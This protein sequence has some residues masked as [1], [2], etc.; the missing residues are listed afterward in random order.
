MRHKFPAEWRTQNRARR[1]FYAKYMTW[2]ENLG[3][4]VVAAVV[5]GIAYSFFYRI[6]D[7]VSA[8]GVELRPVSSIVSSDSPVKVVRWLVDDLAEVERGVPVAEVLVG[9]NEIEAWER[10]EA[11]EEARRLAPDLVIGSAERPMAMTWVAESTG[12]IRVGSE[13]TVEPGGEIYRIEDYSAVVA[14]ATLGGETVN[15]ADVGQ[16]ARFGSISWGAANSPIFRVQSNQGPLVSRK[17]LGSAVAEALAGGLAGYAVRL[18]DDKALSIAGVESVEVEGDALFESGDGGGA[19][20][21]DP[22]REVKVVGTVTGGVASAVVQ[23]S[24]LPADV[25]EALEAEVRKEVEG[26]AVE[27][28]GGESGRLAAVDSLRYV[29]KLKTEGAAGNGARLLS[30]SRVDR[31][32][33]AQLRIDDPPAFLVR[34]MKEAARRGESVTAKVEVKTGTRPI[35]FILL[36]RS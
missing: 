12:T 26:T 29:V 21:L 23:T 2:L 32:F 3:F 25:Q 7:L 9:A 34:S 1:R 24:D 36:K 30:A 22:P 27:T 6:D 28:V 5:L 16:E 35:A 33:S 4:V 18:T 11:T 19:L 17:V 31:K 14:E 20:P 13:E 10:W 8:E 15:R